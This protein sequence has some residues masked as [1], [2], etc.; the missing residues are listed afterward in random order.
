MIAQSGYP[1][2]GING[3][4]GAGKDTVA[5]HLARM[6]GFTHYAFADKLKQAVANLFGITVD[7]VNEFKE[8]MKD[9]LPKGEVHLQIMNETTWAFDWREFLQRFGTEMGRNTFGSEFWV[10]LLMSKPFYGPVV[11]SDAR[12]QNE[13]I[14]IKNQ[15]GKIVRIER[16]GCEAE[17]HV[18][19]REPDFKLVDY[20]IKND[21]DKIHLFLEV[22]KMLTELYGIELHA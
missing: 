6:Y 3:F 4:K 22:E 2:I 20:T 9:D 12:F 15:G 18:S 14:A 7:Q 10:N 8:I 11:I 19:E 17:E 5:G 13:M 16:P 21:L 1:L